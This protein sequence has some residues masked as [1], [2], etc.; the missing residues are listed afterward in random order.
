MLLALALGCDPH[1]AGPPNIVLVS[2]DTLRADHLGSYGDTRGLTPNLDRFAGQAVRFSRATAVAN[3]TLYSHAAL[4]SGRYASELAPM[5]YALRAPADVPVLAEILGLYGYTT[6]AA[7]GGG[8]LAP[9]LGLDR[10]FDHYDSVA[11]WGGLYH[12]VP[13]AL[14]W[15]DTVDGPSL[16]FV[17]GYDTHHRYLKPAPFG[18]LE[19]DGTPHGA[20]EEAVL[21]PSG[22]ARV[23]DGWLVPPSEALAALDYDAAR[24][25]DDEARAAVADL[26]RQVRAGHIGESGVVTLRNTYAGA[27]A[28]ADAMFGL[29]MAGLDERGALDD[30][31]I[32]VFSDHGESLG[33]RGLFNHRFTLSDADLEVPLLIRPPGG[34]TPAEVDDLVT[35]L[36]VL[37]TVLAIAEASPPASLRGHSLVPALEGRPLP[38]RVWA[39]AEGSFRMVR[40][41]DEAG[42]LTYTGLSADHPWLGPVL[43]VSAQDGPG[44]DAAHLDPHRFDTLRDALVSWRKSLPPTPGAEGTLDPAVRDKLRD[45]GYWGGR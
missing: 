12:T 31:W 2:L 7:V 38:E 16:L 23:L 34:T 5:T 26:A 43:E 9:E 19:V 37:P 15:L 22:T 30:S 8:H 28:Y 40:V 39:F 14:R 44:F 29:L 17:H 27:V 6:G 18:Y 21:H 33:E 3:E 1:P 32:L 10:G 35:L 42:A 41:H 11:E 4:F 25:W 20:A 13:A 24:I 45:G 36:D